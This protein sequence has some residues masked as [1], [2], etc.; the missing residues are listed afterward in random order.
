MDFQNQLV[1]IAGSDGP[2]AGAV[3]DAFAREGA[4][5]EFISP[6]LAPADFA[7]QH[8]RIDA[9]ILVLP[10]FPVGITLERTDAEW[11]AGLNQGLLRAIQWIQAVGAQMVAQGRGCILILGGLAGSTGFPGWAIT[12]AVE[13]ALLAL[14]RSLACEWATSNVRVVYLACGAVGD[15]SEHAAEWAARTPLGRTA[16]PE[17]IARVA[18]FLAGERAS[19]TTGTLVHAD[20]G[21]TA[22]G[23]LK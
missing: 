12:S 1:A 13:G 8:T 2:I 23:L 7:R 14:T 19:F 17:E 18:L 22:W 15:D 21:W 3:A 11:Q 9:L 20:G 5:V 4:T 10:T 6:A 16:S